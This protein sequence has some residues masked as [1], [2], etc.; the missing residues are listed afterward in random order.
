MS[1]SI[2]PKTSIFNDPNRK[3]LLFIKPMR[4]CKCSGHCA[5][6][7]NA[8]TRREFIGLM[9]AGVG[10]TLLAGSTAW[11]AF[12]LP[13][14]EFQQWEKE[15]RGPAQPRVYFSDKHTDARMHLGGI[16]TGNFE[17]GAD[18]QLTTWQLFNTLRDGH[19]PFYFVAKA[20][21]TTKLLQTAGGPDWNRIKRIE[22]T[23]EYPA[24][25][26]RFVDDELPVRI[27]LEAFTPYAPLDASLSSMPVAFF[28]FRV[29]NPTAQ[30]QSVSLGAMVTN[31]VGYEAKQDIQG[32]SH[33]NFCG[34]INEPFRGKRDLQVCSCGRKQAR[35]R[36]LIARCAFT[37]P[38]GFA[39][40]K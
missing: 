16:G 35:N 7:E 23:G 17:I 13:R 21:E 33:P 38:R 15:V 34:N 6:Q 9:G 1:Q 8:L 11:G 26:L 39:N 12:E 14:D 20:G 10:G 36:R 18:G 31:P 2:N 30:A 25:T 40:S 19:V 28:R 27:E 37:F 29:H 4:K 5:P 32:V 3:L 24:A 22:M